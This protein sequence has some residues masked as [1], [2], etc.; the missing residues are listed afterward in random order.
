MGLTYLDACL[1]IYTVEEHPV[2]SPLV[3]AHLAARPDSPPAI[4]PLVKLECLVKPLRDADAALERRYRLA[5]D[6]LVV[7]PANDETF[8]AAATLRAHFA[9]RTPDA[10]HL[11]CAQIHGCDRLLTNDD[12]LY[13]AG[14][15]FASS[16][17]DAPFAG[18]S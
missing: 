14:R 11:A 4:S 10:V 6:E 7:L 17:H 2:F 15:G 13:R 16:I 8:E 5:F 3:R 12:R 9:L 18:S 1:L